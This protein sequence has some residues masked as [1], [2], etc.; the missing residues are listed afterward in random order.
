MRWRTTC[1]I[2]AGFV[3]APLV[4]LTGCADGFAGGHQLGDTGIDR[5]V[6]R[7]AAALD[8]AGGHAQVG[9]AHAVVRVRGSD[10][11]VCG[12]G[13]HL[14]DRGEWAGA[15]AGAYGPVGDPG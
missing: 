9:R 1:A 5:A 4:A 6:R 14:G 13:R 7:A 10:G 12:P 2:A 3:A 15:V 8:D 11:V